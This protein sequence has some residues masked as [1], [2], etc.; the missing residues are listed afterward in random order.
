[1]KLGLAMRDL[2]VGGFADFGP[3]QRRLGSVAFI[4]DVN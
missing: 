2:R 3:R 4:T 1:M